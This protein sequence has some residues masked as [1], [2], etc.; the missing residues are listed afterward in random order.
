MCGIAGIVSSLQSDI[1][2]PMMKKMTDALAHRGPD[3]E[4]VWL[5]PQ[6]TAALAHR[7]LAVIDLSFQA[8]QPMHYHDRYSIVFNGEI[9]NYVE[10]K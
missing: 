7:R 3:G 8:A 9:Y 4:G 2:L 6:K 5:S 10:L 1:N